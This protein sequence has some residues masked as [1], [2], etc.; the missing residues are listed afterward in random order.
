VAITRIVKI[1]ATASCPDATREEIKRT[2]WFQ[3]HFADE[4]GQLSLWSPPLDVGN[5]AQW[6]GGGFSV[7]HGSLGW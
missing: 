3:S 5:A 7:L 1:E 4:N 6:Q 2:A